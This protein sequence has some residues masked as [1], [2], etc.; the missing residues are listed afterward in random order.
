MLPPC[1][2][3]KPTAHLQYTL[4]EIGLQQTFPLHLVLS[5]RECSVDILTVVCCN[6]IMTLCELW[7]VPVLSFF[8]LRVSPDD[9]SHSLLLDLVLMP[10]V[11][12]KAKSFESQTCYPSYEVC[13]N[14]WTFMFSTAALD[15]HLLLL[16]KMSLLGVTCCC[17]CVQLFLLS[18]VGKTT[19]VIVM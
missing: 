9:H 1:M 19:C 3:G 11:T 2:S 16:I 10:L 4:L 13:C 7:I 14:C 5:L 6:T 17:M 12:W 18:I 8:P 15:R